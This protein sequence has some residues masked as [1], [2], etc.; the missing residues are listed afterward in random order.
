MR[1]V[2]W[3]IIGVGALGVAL[4]GALPAGATTRYTVASHDTLY[5]IARHFG[6]PV[7]SLIEANGL[8]DPSRLRVGQVLTIPDSASPVRVAGGPASPPSRGAGWGAT[9]P[10]TGSTG[11]EG[12]GDSSGPPGVI[13]SLVA[14]TTSRAPDVPPA[15]SAAT[16]V[17]RPGDTLYH[18]A[19][20]HGLTV[21]ELQ[22]ANHLGASDALRVGQAL[23]IPTA[24]RG[25]GTSTPQAP[26]GGLVAVS[27]P[28]TAARD[29]GP[30]AGAR[31]GETLAVPGRVTPNMGT[32]ALPSM[33]TTLLARRTVATAMQYL[34][35]PYSWGGTSRAGV[36]CSGL[37]Y[38][39]YAP[40][41]PGLPRLSYDQWATGVPVDPNAL[42][43][44]DLVFFDTDGSG[45]SHVGIYIGDGRFVHAS[46]TAHRV[47]VDG[48]DESYYVS[49]YLG[50]RRV[51]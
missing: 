10:A 46:G 19:R 27:E 34:G 38:L 1:V 7:S 32:P 44:G 43:P 11:S 18:V 28:P 42:A 2:A 51:L 14:T 9:V 50:A 13:G 16:Y 23:V 49:H 12:G 45:A 35:T 8:G 47:V 29:A 36:D 24:G 30:V 25:A 39:V 20:I 15:L 33:R 48:F 5:S 40:Y 41:V 26:L 31:Y 4:A 6:V 3:V 17:V 22:D 21:A 37:V